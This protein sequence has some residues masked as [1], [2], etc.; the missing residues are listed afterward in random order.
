MFKKNVNSQEQK[1]TLVFDTFE[2]V[3]EDLLKK[4]YERLCILKSC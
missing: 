1:Y 4:D 3:F 2:K